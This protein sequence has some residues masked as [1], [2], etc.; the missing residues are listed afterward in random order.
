MQKG[1]I[2]TLVNVLR[3]YFIS[4]GKSGDVLQKEDVW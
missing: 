1:D 3:E 4:H 2:L